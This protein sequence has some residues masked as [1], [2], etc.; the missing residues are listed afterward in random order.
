MLRVGTDCSGLDAPLIALKE[1][2]IDYEYVFCSEINQKLIQIIQDENKPQI[3]YDNII[4]RNHKLL[5]QIDLYIA[6]FPCPSFS[7][8]SRYREGFDSDRGSLFFHC[9]E[10]IKN[11]KPKYFILEN[12]KGIKTHNKGETFKLI[13]NYLNKLTDYNI[14]YELINS[15]YFTPQDRTRLYIIGISKQIT[16]DILNFNTYNKQEKHIT[17]IININNKTENIL[18]FKKT[19]L[20]NEII[21]KKNI[22]EDDWWIINLNTSCVNF[23]TAKKNL[24]P[25]LL[26]SCQMYYINKLKRYLTLPELQKLQGLESLNLSHYLGKIEQ[27]TAIGNSMTVPV[28]KYLLTILLI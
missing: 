6:G 7:T 9:Y 13:Q 8:A 12:V 24:S 21:T 25:T 18:S 2:N 4:K 11:A 26:T 28:I 3:V 22:K 5:P 14:Y 17:D 20:L 23:A 16:N 27:I 19:K 10:T 1:L 15:K